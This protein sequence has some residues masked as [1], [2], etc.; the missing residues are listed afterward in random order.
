MMTDKTNKSLKIKQ[1]S[2]KISIHIKKDIFE[3]KNASLDLTRP[4]LKINTVRMSTYL[5]SLSY[6]VFLLCD[7]CRPLP[8][9]DDGRWGVE[10]N[11][12]KKI[13]KTWDKSVKKRVHCSMFESCRWLQGFSSWKF[14]KIQNRSWRREDQVKIPRAATDFKGK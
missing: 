14:A 5:I 9:L 13:K 8:I 7:R 12:K 3:E 1:E 10:P 6:S 2:L 4:Q 11:L